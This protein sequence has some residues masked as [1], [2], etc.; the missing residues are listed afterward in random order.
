[1]KA[2]IINDNG[3]DFRVVP[4]FD[5]FSPNVLH[6]AKNTHHRHTA[7]GYAHSDYFTV[8]CVGRGTLCPYSRAAGANPQCD[9]VFRTESAIQSSPRQR[10]GLRYHKTDAPC[11]G[12]TLKPNVLHDAAQRFTLG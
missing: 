2:L 4:V 8:C 6:W 7:G 11:R 1:M 12:S 10:L 5:R 3:H 9:F